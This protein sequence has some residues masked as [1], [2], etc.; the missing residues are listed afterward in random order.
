M[1]YL[2]RGTKKYPKKG[3]RNKKIGI[4]QDDREKYPWEFSP[5]R[6]SVTVQRLDTGDYTIEGL[7]QK[8]AIEKKGDWS[9]FLYNISSVDR[10]RFLRTLSRLA[11][12]PYPIIV[13]ED[14][15]RNLP[16]ALAKI[17]GTRLTIDSVYY[18]LTRIQI[19]YGIK[20]LLIGT[21]ADHQRRFL[22]QMMKVLLE[23]KL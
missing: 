2:K 5:R 11:E 12:Y 1:T 13:I 23:S 19:E 9:E 18:W 4:L 8:V 10:K 17:P 21:R 7:E 15:I 6:Y 14:C 16:K 20:V 3:I 22:E